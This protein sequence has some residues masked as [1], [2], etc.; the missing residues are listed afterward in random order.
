MLLYILFK[1][2][3]FLAMVPF[4]TLLDFSSLLLK[5]FDIQ[6]S[7]NQMC[8]LHIRFFLLHLQ[9]LLLLN[10]QFFFPLPIFLIF[11]KFIIFRQPFL[12]FHFIVGRLIER[13]F[14]RLNEISLIDLIIARYFYWI[15]GLILIF[16]NIFMHDAMHAFLLGLVCIILVTF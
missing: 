9:Q 5:S 16:L 1:I 13:N 2:F 15:I 6:I 8:R 7:I 14:L 11:K 12:I 3:L 4:Y 10:F